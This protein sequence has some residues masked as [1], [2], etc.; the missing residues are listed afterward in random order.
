MKHLQTT[1][2][3]YQQRYNENLKASSSALPLYHTVAN[4]FSIFQVLWSTSEPS[5]TANA[6]YSQ[7]QEPNTEKTKDSQ[8]IEN[9]L[10]SLRLYQNF[11]VEDGQGNLLPQRSAQLLLLLI[12]QRRLAALS[13][14]WQGFISHQLFL[15]SL[16][17]CKMFWFTIHFVKLS[18]Y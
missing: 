7:S 5:P 2:K 8:N 4:W 15:H 3:K 14:I 10:N 1:W 17:D 6:T 11:P 9:G 16:T 18:I 13:L 12:H